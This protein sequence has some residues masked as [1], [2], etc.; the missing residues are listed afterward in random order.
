M[1]NTLCAVRLPA[2]LESWAVTSPPSSLVSSSVLHGPNSHITG[3]IQGLKRVCATCT[4]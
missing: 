3:L 1:G 2:C 4:R